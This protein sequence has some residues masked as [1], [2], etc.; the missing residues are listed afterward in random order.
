[1]NIL[2]KCIGIV[3][4]VSPQVCGWTVLLYKTVIQ[5]VKARKKF[6][7]R[8]ILWSLFSFKYVRI[9]SCLALD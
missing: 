6:S 7:Q 1:M 5:H 8:G 4:T 9:E 3:T 2:C